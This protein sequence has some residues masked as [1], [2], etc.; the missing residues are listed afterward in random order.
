MNRKRNFS[1]AA[2][3][4]A[5]FGVLAVSQGM[6]EKAASA[7]AKAGSVQVPRFE[8]DPT[9]P[10]AAAESLVSGADDRRVGRRTRSRVDHPSRRF[11]VAER[12]G[13]RR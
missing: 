4:V 10:K 2:T 7:Q 6:L 8:V 12:A 3:F 9:F 11:A 5:T 13:A 1:I